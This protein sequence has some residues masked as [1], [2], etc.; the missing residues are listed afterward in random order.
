MQNEIIGEAADVL[1]EHSPDKVHV[2]KYSNND[3]F[4]LRD[5]DRSFN[6][7]N[8][9]SNLR[10]KGLNS[11]IKKVVDDYKTNGYGNP[12]AMEACLGQLDAIV[13][14]QCGNHD[15]CKHGKWCTYLKVKTENLRWRAREIALEAANVSNRPHDGKNMSL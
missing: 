15:E 13:L 11:D 4:K 12:E 1:T 3:F 5:E 7:V 9:L 8:C 10:I 2:M 14:H 6:G